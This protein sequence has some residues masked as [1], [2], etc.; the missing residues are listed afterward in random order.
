LGHPQDYRQDEPRPVPAAA[1]LVIALC[2]GHG[3]PA[4]LSTPRG[5]DDT[6]RP[7]AARFA[8]FQEPWKAANASPQY[9]A[10]S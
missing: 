6:C 8:R 2:F 1:D 10:G 3:A 9:S 7:L 5:A 4:I